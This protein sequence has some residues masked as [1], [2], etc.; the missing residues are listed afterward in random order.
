NPYGVVITLVEEREL[1]ALIENM[2]GDFK[3]N[4]YIMNEQQDV[5]VSRTAG[6]T[7]SDSEWMNILERSD[8]EGISSLSVAN[9]ELSIVRTQSEQ[10]GWSFAIVMPTEQFFNLVIERR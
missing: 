8:E 3:G 1:T 4:M 9:Q 7:L 10:T 2:L 6:L 5:L